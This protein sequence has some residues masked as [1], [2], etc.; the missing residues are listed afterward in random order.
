MEGARGWWGEGG[1]VE[2]LGEGVFEGAADA[3]W[4]YGVG[5]DVLDG[6]HGGVCDA[7]VVDEGEVMEVRGDVEGE[8]VHGYPAFDVD[9]DGGD[10]VLA[11]PDA[12]FSVP[13]G[14]GNA[15]AGK[16]ANQRFF[17]LPEVFPQVCAVPGKVH[18]GVADYLARAMVGY[19]SASVG[20]DE[21]DA[22]LGQHGF[23]GED[24]IQTAGA[25]EGDYG[26]VFEED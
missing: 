16:G 11:D 4:G 21:R 20:V 22:V 18:D 6:G 10:L 13:P 12:G 14:P 24:V 26:G 25:A 15:E 19:V 5:E 8:A 3:G 23:G 17:E 7:A 9:S 1:E 2:E